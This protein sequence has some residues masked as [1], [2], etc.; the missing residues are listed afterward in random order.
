M[1]YAIILAGGKGERF[2]GDLPKQF[3]PLKGKSIVTVTIEIFQMLNDIDLIIPV[4]P[5]KY[6]DSI[7]SEIDRSK[8]RKIVRVVEGGA[9]R[10]GSVYNALTSVSFNAGDL[11]IIHDA[12]RPFISPKIIKNIIAAVKKYGAAGTYVRVTDTV[13]EIESEI[14]KSIRPREN[15]YYAQTPQGFR[16]RIIRDAHEKA[17]KKGI[18]EATDD[19]SIA[20]SGGYE[21]GMVEGS[22][23]NF[24]ITTG[25]DYSLAK[26]ISK[27]TT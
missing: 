8:W 17:M 22:Y 26:L 19:I 11:I 10:Q 24:K 15:L 14:V 4:L 1:N 20:I 2:G 3:L 18:T 7:D 27:V 25:D 21:V 12:A 13:A 16:Y 5:G 6:L 23:S 9:T